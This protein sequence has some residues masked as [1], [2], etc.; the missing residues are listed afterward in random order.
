MSEVDVVI[1]TALKEEYEAVRDVAATSDGVVVW[2]QRDST[3]PTPYLF[4][5][6][7]TAAAQRISLALARPTRM[8]AAATTP[9]AS[10]L[11]ERLKPQC[12]AMCG[13]C[14]GN[15]S[16]VALGDVIIAETVYSY[17]EGKQDANAFEG[18]HRQ[19]PMSELWVRAAQD[20]VPDG[21]PSFGPA[22]EEEA[23]NWLLER[24]Y[25][26]EA[27]RSHPA[28]SRYFPRGKWR[29]GVQRLVDAA[30]VVH[31]GMSLALTDRGR[32]FVEKTLFNDVDGPLKLPCQ[33]KVGPIASG[34][35]VVKDGITWNSLK[36]WGVRSVLGLEME[37]AA[38]GSTAHRLGVPLWVIA[39]GVMDYAD[40]RKDDRYKPFAARASAEVLLRFLVNQNLALPSRLDAQPPARPPAEAAATLRKSVR[41][42]TSSNEKERFA[43]SITTWM[44]RLK[45]KVEW[46]TSDQTQVLHQLR[47]RNRVLIT[48]CA[49]SGKTLLVAE[50]AIRLDAAGVR[51]LV[52]CHNPNLAR[53][54]TSLIANPAIDTVDFA[55]F[56]S[57]LAGTAAPEQGGWTALEEP[58]DHELDL[59]FDAVSPLT[60]VYQAI[61][62]DEG[63]DFREIWWTLLDALLDHSRT[64]TL[65]IFC[66]DNQAL[67]P[68]RASYPIDSE[69][70]SMSRNCRNGGNIFEI[71]RRCHRGAPLVSSFLSGDGVAKVTVFDEEDFGIR[72]EDA[73]L[74]ACKYADHAEIRV[75]TNEHS[76][77]SSRINGFKFF[78]RAERG[79]RAAVSRTL[80]R[81]VIRL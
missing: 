22:S 63:Q 76:A 56:V 52:L 40:P 10:S 9:I 4:G 48:G 74:D 59:A 28:R 78:R 17:D 53:H 11:V 31:H 25:A 43:A 71:V 69:P 14:A 2:E 62:V 35:V 46:L 65:Y 54:L 26:G 42:T 81:C 16:S 51:T 12:L 1:V 15:P 37:A 75:L 61:I 18:D 39:K 68:H 7:V 58:L 60:A 77:E 32:S 6:Y 3:S 57:R 45:R 66:D 79:W 23:K 29:D 64:R 24:V 73:L 30:L 5:E 67:L 49:G 34:N 72:L 21:L 80:M 13:V 50:K 20:M 33:I 38:I 47:Y 27:P 36:R 19:T 70:V 41:G 55:T 8:G 44:A